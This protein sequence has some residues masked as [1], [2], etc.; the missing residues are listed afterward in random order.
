VGSGTADVPVSAQ[1]S[2]LTE[3]TIYFF[4]VVATNATG[5]SQG[6]IR[7]LTTLLNPPPVAVAH[8]NETVYTKGPGTDNSTYGSTVVTL[9]GSDSF[10]LY[11]TI[12]SYLWEK[13]AGTSNPTLANP[14]ADNTTFTAPALAYGE[15]DNLVYRLTVTDNRTLTGTDNIWK[16]VKWGYFDDFSTDTTGAYQVFDTLNTGGTFGYDAP[17]Q[18]VRVVAGDNT[19]IKILKLVPISSSG[20]FSFDFNPTSQVGTGSISIRLNDGGAYLEIST[21]DGKVRKVWPAQPVDEAVFPF[22]YAQGST[23]HITI[24]FSPIVTTFEVTGGAGVPP[25]PVSLIT[26]TNSLAPVYFEIESTQQSSYFDNI[27]LEAAP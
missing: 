20:V 21:L 27:K 16:F 25:A 22:T 10:D 11:G 13:I 14:T 9:L 23:Y 18:R 2:G 3:G 24:T 1:I 26:N 7:F 12:T 19:G 4:R 15:T 8:F 6:A 17:G 5:T